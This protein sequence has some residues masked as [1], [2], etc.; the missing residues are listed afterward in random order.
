MYYDKY[1]NSIEAED[2]MRLH[3]DPDY[4]TVGSDT[5]GKYFISTVWMGIDYG[6]PGCSPIIFETMVFNDGE[7]EDLD[8]SRYKTE[9]KAKQGHTAMLYKWALKTSKDNI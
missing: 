2:F 6:F 1:G 3:K 5:V 4:R 9:E 8:C 7:W